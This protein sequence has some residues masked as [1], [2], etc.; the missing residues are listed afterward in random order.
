MVGMV[1][2]NLFNSSMLIIDLFTYTL[3]HKVRLMEAL[4]TS[5]LS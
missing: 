5:R 3:K 1:Y 4:P 2:L